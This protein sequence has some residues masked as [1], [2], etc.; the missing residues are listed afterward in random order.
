MKW[1]SE[2]RETNGLCV[3]FQNE[4]GSRV[5]AYW[6]QFTSSWAGSMLQ[7]HAPGG[8][9]PEHATTSGVTGFA[10]VDL[11]TQFFCW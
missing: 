7:G 8:V 5:H 3:M 6:R 4:Q 9:L 1:H 11:N 10:A 2:L